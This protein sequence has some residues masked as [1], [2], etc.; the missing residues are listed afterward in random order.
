M[1]KVCFLIQ[2]L[3][4]FSFVL[5]FVD[6]LQIDVYQSATTNDHKKYNNTWKGSIL[7]TFEY[8]VPSTLYMI[9]F[10][11]E[12]SFTFRMIKLCCAVPLVPMMIFPNAFILSGGT[13][14]IQLLWFGFVQWYFK[15]IWF[16]AVLA[17]G[18]KLNANVIMLYDFYCMSVVLPCWKSEEKKVKHASTHIANGQYSLYFGWW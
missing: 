2:H 1:I 16:M 13:K 18:L 4:Y 12:K 14:V 3:P 8:F 5:F 9:S 10:I 11:S 6:C 17:L 7:Y 15:M